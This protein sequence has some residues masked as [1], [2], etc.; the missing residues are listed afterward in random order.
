MEYEFE[1]TKMK[2]VK[3][4]FG[5]NDIVVSMVKVLKDGKFVKFAKLNDSL[6]DAMKAKGFVSIKK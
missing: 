5:K 6:L 3:N 2:L 1:I 4:D